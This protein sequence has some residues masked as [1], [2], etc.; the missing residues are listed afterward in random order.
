MIAACLAVCAIAFPDAVALRAIEDALPASPPPRPA[1][2]TQRPA[3]MTVVDAQGLD[4]DRNLTL[5]ALQ[6]LV[7]R[8]GPRLFV[9]GMNPFN[10]EADRFWVERL[11]Q[12]YGIVAEAADFE[13]AL[14]QYGPELGG[15]IVYP[16]DSS[17]SENVA[18][19][20]AALLGLL[21]VAS[22]VRG[23]A[24]QATGLTVRYDLTG[25]FADRLEAARWALEH[26][27]PALEPPDLACLDDRTWLQIR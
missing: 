17:Q 22:E 6:G 25:C 1:F 10:R 19:M 21:P 15:L 14:R 9:I 20:A 4:L 8:R 16:V 24:E 2:A 27:A 26:L 11:G 18:C 7:N 13:G 3:T 23:Q 5:L 12:R